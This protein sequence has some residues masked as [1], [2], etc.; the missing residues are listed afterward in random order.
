MTTCRI[1]LT[2]IPTRRLLFGGQLRKRIILQDFRV[3]SAPWPGVDPDPD[4]IIFWDDNLFWD[5]DLN[6]SDE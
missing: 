2:E 4:P 5:D 6:W 3:T 1:I